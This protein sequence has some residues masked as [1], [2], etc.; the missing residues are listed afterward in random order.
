MAITID[1]IA[2]AD[3]D[4]ALLALLATELQE[5]LPIEI[6][7][8]RAQ[9]HQ[10]LGALPRGLRAM[11]GTHEFNV[12]MTRDDLVCHFSNQND[13][14]DLHATLNGLRELE[15]PEVADAFEEAW[16]ALEP[17]LEA[18]RKN[19]VSNEKLYEWLEEI[20]AEEKIDSLDEIIWNFR[21]EAGPLGLHQSWVLYA[22]KYPE[23]CIVAEALANI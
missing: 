20:G 7:G 1:S 2:A 5:L 4:G 10:M 9:F 23:R 18:L 17:N 6:H 13:D 15:A 16:K 21:D 19:Q 11:A 14:R 3:S 8:D 22:R 12:S